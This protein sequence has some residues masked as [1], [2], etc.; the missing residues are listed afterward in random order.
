MNGASPLKFPCAQLPVTKN[1][2]HNLP[3]P[4]RQ[5]AD[6]GTKFHSMQIAILGA[7]MVGRAM[8]AD[9]SQKYSV[10]AFDVSGHDLQL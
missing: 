5:L 1:Y 2:L 9:L 8:A 10:T 3:D 7:G 6:A 4:L